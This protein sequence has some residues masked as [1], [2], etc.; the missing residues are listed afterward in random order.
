[1]RAILKREFKTYFNTATGFIFMTVFLGLTGIFFALTNLF[2]G[3]PYYNPVLDSTTFIF[4]V[5][6]PMITMKT[7]AEE[8]HQKI[9]QLLLTSPVRLTGIVLGKYFAA[10]GLFL[11]TLLITC[12]YPIILGFY[13][14][15]SVWEIVGAY[16][17]FALLGSSFIAV[18]IF[19]SSLTENQVTAAVGTFGALLLL[20][21]ID[22]MQQGLPT[23]LGSGIAFAA[24]L[25]VIVSVIV[26]YA[27][28][29]TYFSSAVLLLGGIAI[30][31]VY[32]VNKT[33]YEGFTAK[34]LGWFSLTQRY[35]SFTMGI[36][37]VSTI[38]Y[39]ITFSAAFLFLTVRVLD[40]RRWS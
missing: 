21:I 2:T 18:G 37:D 15:V 12:I 39:Y 1:M 6:V 14:P 36:L 19:I 27:M 7:L 35:Q 33:L 10:V 11:I 28:K 8:R 25:V 20:W 29:N 24:L 17:G 23:T 3:D 16:I 13:G 32:F 31:V 9:D 4:L 30:T 22:W 40:K 38:I 34:F 26:H 5:L